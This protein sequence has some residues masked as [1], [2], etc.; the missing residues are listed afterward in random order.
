MYRIETGI[1]V[2][3][4]APDFSLKDSVGDTVKLSD[5]IRKGNVVLAFYRG[6]ADRYSTQWLAGLRDDYLVIRGLDAEV[7]AVSA[8]DARTQLDTG[9]RYDLPFRLLSDP[10]CRV[11]RMYRV[12]DD[13]AKTA[14]SAAFIVDRTG[15]IRY[16]YVSGAPPDLPSNTEIIRHLRSI[17]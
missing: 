1:D 11:V 5:H 7:L 12:Y 13:F 3:D 2:G 10:E 9:G 16:K 17:V 8:D 6:E 15:R 14:T 4:S